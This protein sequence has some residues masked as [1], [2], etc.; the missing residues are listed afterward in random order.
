MKLRGLFIAMTMV[1]V[2]GRRM[3]LSIAVMPPIL[4]YRDATG[5]IEQALARVT[6]REIPDKNIRKA[7]MH[8]R[9]KKK[10]A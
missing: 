7:L 3:S 4:H 5:A 6:I 10:A 8:R 9:E 2:R 1:K